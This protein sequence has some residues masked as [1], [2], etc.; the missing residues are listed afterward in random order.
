VTVALDF[1]AQA[2]DSPSARRYR[3]LAPV[4]FLAARFDAAQV[5]F[6][7]AKNEL[8]GTASFGYRPVLR[9]ALRFDFSQGRGDFALED[10][11]E[12]SFSV[13]IGY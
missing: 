5:K 9:S 8:R 7:E 2:S 13:A 10:N 6:D 4:L 12:A 11:W 3:P 1:D